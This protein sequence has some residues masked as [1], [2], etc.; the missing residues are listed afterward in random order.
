MALVLSDQCFPTK[1]FKVN[2]DIKFENLFHCNGDFC[3]FPKYKNEIL[4]STNVI[5]DYT[6]Q[7][8]VDRML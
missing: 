5:F 4:P 1:L 3:G 2:K 6:P 8:F 7:I